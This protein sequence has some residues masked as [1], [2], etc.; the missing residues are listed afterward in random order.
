[1]GYSHL[2]AHVPSYEESRSSMVRSLNGTPNFKL[3]IWFSI[4]FKRTSEI[5]HKKSS[6]HIS[7]IKHTITIFVNL[8]LF[9]HFGTVTNIRTWIKLHRYWRML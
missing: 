6:R 9:R 2:L 5:K 7:L 1:M 4:Y 8:G 3:F